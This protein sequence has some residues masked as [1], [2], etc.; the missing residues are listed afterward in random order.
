MTRKIAIE[1]EGG[2]VESRALARAIYAMIEASAVEFESIFVDG[3]SMNPT[4][5]WNHEGKKIVLMDQ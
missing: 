2:V 4:D 5:G 1:F 3:F